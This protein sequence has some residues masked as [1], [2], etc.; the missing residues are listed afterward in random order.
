MRPGAQII[1]R[2]A[3]WPDR[4]AVE[5]CGI[6]VGDLLPQLHLVRE[7]VEFGQEDRGLEGVEAAVD[8]DPGVVVFVAA[9]AVDSDGIEGGGKLVVIGEAHSA[10]AVAAQR[11]GGEEGG[12]GNVGQGSCPFTLVHGAEVLGGIFDDE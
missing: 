6:A 1:R 12:A 5:Q 10:V 3:G 7:D 11:F 8:A 9:F 4:R 2:N